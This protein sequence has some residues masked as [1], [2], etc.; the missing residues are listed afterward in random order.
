SGHSTAGRLAALAPEQHF[1]NWA[2][3]LRLAL[4]LT[5]AIYWTNR[6]FR[7]KRM[8]AARHKRQSAVPSPIGA[9]YDK[10]NYW[11]S[12]TM[13]DNCDIKARW[14]GVDE[15][16]ERWLKERQS[17]IVQFCALSGVNE[18]APQNTNNRN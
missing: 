10:P 15:L 11:G 4:K 9:L 1:F 7:P 17:L 16:L 13:L 8:P 2:S 5:H 12:S 3:A 14:S 18:F 6:P